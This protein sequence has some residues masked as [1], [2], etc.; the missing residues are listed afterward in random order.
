MSAVHVLERLRS[1]DLDAVREEAMADVRSG[2]KTRRA[3][4]VKVLRALDGLKRSG[5]SVED[6]L[7]HR[8]P[9]IPAD[10]RPYAVAGETFIPGDAN[11]LYADLIRAKEV[12]EGTVREVGPKAALDTARYLRA[13]VRATYGYGE[14]PN[15]KLK[16]RR[17]SGFLQKILG[18]GPKTSFVQQKLLA[19]PQ[20]MVGRGVI[21]PDPDL[22]MDEIG[23]PED[24]LWEQYRNFIQRRLV[25][26]GIPSSRALRLIRDRDKT[27]E[28]ALLAEMKVRP[29][30]MSRAPAWHRQ[31]FL[32]AWPKLVK[33]NNIM[34]SPLIAAGLGA[35][36]DGD[37]MAIH[38]PAL[39]ETVED[40]KNK[41]MPSR[42]AFSVRNRDK[43]LPVPKHEMTLG[44]ASAQLRP[45]GNV[46]RFATRGEAL[47]AVG[48]GEVKLHDE[49]EID[50]EGFGATGPGPG[51]P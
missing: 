32:A 41:L 20:D 18:S 1:L 34:I 13:S 46:F 3:K 30:M 17:V 21:S 15:P 44:L 26:S 6:L 16:S 36:Y 40:A 23:V 25:S 8:V 43:T 29:V 42:M 5:A 27:A 37:T 24:M 50:D 31:S 35:D 38:T 45:S 47:A 9:V 28:Q 49:I 39:P 19:K 48:R 11:E 22:G 10:F 12:H 4:A 51:Y 2:K 7:I 14:T 33:G